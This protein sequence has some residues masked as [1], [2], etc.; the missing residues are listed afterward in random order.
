MVCHRISVLF[1][2]ENV[3][4]KTRTERKKFRDEIN[5]LDQKYEEVRRENDV[6]LYQY[7]KE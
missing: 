1:E 7:V 3:L 4:N 5:K 6:I 2:M